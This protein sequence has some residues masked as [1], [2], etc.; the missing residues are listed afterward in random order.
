MK[1]FYVG[2]LMIIFLLT[3]CTKTQE[4][5]RIHVEWPLY[6]ITK[7]E[8]PVGHLLGTMH[9]GKQGWFP[10]PKQMTQVVDD[11]DVVI[12]EGHLQDFYAVGASWQLADK[13]ANHQTV[14]DF[15]DDTQQEELQEKLATYSSIPIHLNEMTL[16]EL[17]NLLSSSY[18]QEDGITEGVEYYLFGYLHSKKQLA[19]NIGLET[20]EENLI[21]GNKSMEQELQN[22]PQWVKH[23]PTY[24]E[25][26]GNL[27]RLF[28][29]YEKNELESF[30]LE[31][32]TLEILQE[33][34]LLIPRNL[35][36]IDELT[37]QLEANNA[38]FIA[39]G[40]AHLYYENG[41]I[42]LLEEE[43]FEVEAV[44]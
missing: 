36:W 24:E 11:A 9:I 20:I 26:L 18:Y 31:E 16:L 44:K 17:D 6:T 12:T 40:A 21:A 25:G 33:D 27:E 37:D 29:T 38:T 14:T 39:V 19:K 2:M 7:D 13:V 3:G 23:L 22:D 15:I 10:L 32:E 5:E 1:K 34:V 4:V 42:D 28:T 35:N 41:L 43:G 8:E 30:L